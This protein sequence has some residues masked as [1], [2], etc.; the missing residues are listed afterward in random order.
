MSVRMIQLFKTIKASPT[1][2]LVAYM[3][4]DCHNEH[5][6]QCDPSISHLEVTTSLSDRAIEVAIQALE[7]SGHLSVSRRRGARNSYLLHPKTSERASPVQPHLNGATSEPPSLPPANLLRQ[8]SE[9]PSPKPELTGIQPSASAENPPP[10]KVHKI[11]LPKPP[12]PIHPPDPRHQEFINA[13]AATWKEWNNG[14][15]YDVQPKDVK[16][17]QLFL[18]RC[19]K[20]VDE[21]MAGV[22]WCFERHSK[23]GQMAAKEVRNCST[24]TGFVTSYSALVAYANNHRELKSRR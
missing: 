17:L 12:K 1:Q 11:R 19:S 9:P 16:Q 20:T 5:T 6:G 10:L 18:R 21:L 22:V 23:D 13:Y 3:L 24:I 15:A 7:H 14:E 8:T 2:R 4:A